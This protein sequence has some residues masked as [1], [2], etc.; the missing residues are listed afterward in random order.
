MRADAPTTSINY[1]NFFSLPNYNVNAWSPDNLDTDI[2]GAGVYKEPNYDQSYILY[3]DRFVEK[4][5]FIKMRNIAL[6]YDLPRNICRQVGLQRVRFRV[7]GNNL[8]TVWTANNKGI[9][10]E[11]IN[12]CYGTRTFSATPSATFSINVNF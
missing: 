9:D 2:P 11:A 3:A 12:P 7:Q 4:A 5:D 6:S 10:P 1:I 8:W